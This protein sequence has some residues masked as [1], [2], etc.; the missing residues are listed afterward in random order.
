MAPPISV[1]APQP[2]PPPPTSA[3]TTTSSSASASGDNKSYSDCVT[4]ICS[5]NCPQ[6]CGNLFLP[7]P[8]PSF[9]DDGDDSGGNRIS[10][11]MASLIAVLAAA[12]LLLFYYTVISRLCLRRRRRSRNSNLHR[13]LRAEILDLDPESSRL[14]PMVHDPT[15]PAASGLDESFIRQITVFKYRRSDG[16]IDGT[17]CAVCLSEFNEEENLRLM[18]NCE[19]AFH[20]PCIDTWLKTH[21]NCPL[22]RSTMNPTPPPPARPANPGPNSVSGG[23]GGGGGGQSG[24]NA[25]VSVAA[26]M[27]VQRRSDDA[28][29][30]IRELENEVIVCHESSGEEEGVTGEER[31]NGE[32]EVRK[33]E[34]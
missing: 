25:A 9:L 26:A 4:G 8:P 14:D 23:G 3:A 11:L 6:W 1:G 33:G 7:P 18:P 12:F 13:N 34:C 27:Q 5:M 22:C 15:R 16:L 21:S 29:L 28:V 24:G 32:A 19:H 2:W 30:V 10:P 17:D 20:I 31:E